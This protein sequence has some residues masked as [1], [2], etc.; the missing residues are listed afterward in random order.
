VRKLSGSTAEWR[1]IARGPDVLFHICS[2]PDKRGSWTEEEF[3]AAGRSDWEDFARHWRHHWPDLGGTVVEIG[4]GGGRLTHVLA[5][6]FDRVVALDV[7]ADMLERAR[8][9]SPGNVELHQVDGAEV[10]AADASVDGVFSVH[11][12]QHLEDFA[13]LAAYLAEVRRVLR[14]GG[15]LMVHVTVASGRPPL[16]RR[17]RAELELWRSRRALRR[18]E[19]HTSVRMNHYR[20]EDV[21]RTLRDLGFEGVELRVFPVRSHDYHHSFFL[22]RVPAG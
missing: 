8:A 20:M 21:F 17:A 6:T 4:C 5:E 14:P 22:A 1:A 3:Y 19:E 16:L 13:M 15:S 18:G 2:R 12:F 7:S 10:P 11:V 9:A